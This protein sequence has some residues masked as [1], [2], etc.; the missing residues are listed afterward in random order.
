VRY[1]LRSTRLVLAVL[2][3]AAALAA[4]ALP[5]HGSAA[6]H[7]LAVP[8]RANIATPLPQGV[9]RLVP[10]RFLRAP[11]GRWW[12]AGGPPRATKAS[13]SV[14]AAY[15][16]SDETAVRWTEFL[17]ELVH[18]D[19]LDGLTLYLA[20]PPEV[21]DICQSF[22]ALGCY[23]P[24]STEIVSI[25]EVS[26]GIRPEAVVTHEYGHYIA[27]HRDNAPWDA[28]DWGT[29]RWATVLNVC[30]RAKESK[31]FPGAEDSRYFLNPGEGFAETYRFLNGQP[32]G[33]VGLDWPIVDRV[34]YPNARSLEAVRRDVLQPWTK[35]ATVRLTGR[36]GADGRK[37]LK[38]PTP[39]DGKLD[40]D[41][42]GASVGGSGLSHRQV[43]GLRRMPVELVGNPRATFVLNV[44]RP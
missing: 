28:L 27:S 41:V 36:L 42:S 21:A 39:L 14:S 2:G 43:C 1:Q 33:N 10:A 4:G 12:D 23:A 31:L 37:L 44:T 29:K 19:E 32:T 7:Q 8:D 5:E 13:V 25:G 16:G 38:V 22:D 24:G 3:S 18:G 34:F 9:T 17:A 20:T 15:A 6:T 26:D 35:P 40:L 11:A 30:A